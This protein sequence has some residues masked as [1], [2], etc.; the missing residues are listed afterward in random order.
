M[1]T[2]HHKTF[3][4]GSSKLTVDMKKTGVHMKELFDKKNISVAEIQK[5]L[6]LKSLQSVYRWYNGEALPTVEHLYS[7]AC[8]LHVPIEELLV[9]KTETISDERVVDIIQ[10]CTGKMKESEKIRRAYWELLG[11]VLFPNENCDL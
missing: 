5:K 4:G 6:G 9:F 7:L 11:V 2:Y 8:M 1:L 3:Q 10:W